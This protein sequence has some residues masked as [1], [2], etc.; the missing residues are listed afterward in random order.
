M[1]PQCTGSV[2][3]VALLILL[4]TVLACSRG[5]L[6]ADTPRIPPGLGGRLLFT[7]KDGLETLDLGTAQLQQLVAAPPRARVTSARWSPTGTQIAYTVTPQEVGTDVRSTVYVASA[8]GTGAR[9]VVAAEAANVLYQWP[10][11]DPDG[12]R[13]YVLRADPSGTRI[14][15]VQIDTG[16]RQTI[17]ERAADFDVSRDGSMLAFVRTADAGATLNL[18]RL[19]TAGEPQILATARPLQTMAAPR[20]K[21]DNSAVLFSL[22]RPQEVEDAN[23]SLPGWANA[24]SITPALAHGLPQDLYSVSTSGGSAQLAVRLGADD[25]VSTWSPAADRIAALSIASLGIGSP[26]GSLTPILMPGG[27]GSVDWAP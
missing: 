22:S 4:T 26:G 9:A 10:T 6:P 5:E 16:E 2:L 8:D 20:F 24:F 15:R 25:P 3:R 19:P 11:W 23:P 17:V 7:W 27:Y 12:S 18:L 13:L 21:P 1:T 14:E